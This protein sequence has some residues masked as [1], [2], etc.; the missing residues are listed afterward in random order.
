MTGTNKS[1]KSALDGL[2]NL[3]TGQKKEKESG[4]SAKPA[5]KSTIK[6]TAKPTA[7]K[8]TKPAVSGKAKTGVT[9]PVK[10]GTGGTTKKAQDS[11]KAYKAEHDPQ[12]QAEVLHSKTH[13]DLINAAYKAAEKLG[14]APWVLLRAAGWGNFTDDRGKKYDGPIIDDLKGLDEAQKKALKDVLGL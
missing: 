13:Q 6:S 8:I 2:K 5:V 14:I 9:K 12:K 11:L 10:T 3:I 4:G 1:T 7:S